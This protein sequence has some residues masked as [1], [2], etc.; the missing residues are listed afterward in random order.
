VAGCGSGSGRRTPSAGQLPLVP[1]ARI[2]A[3]VRACD[4]GSSTYCAIDL[5]VLDH[6][7]S[8]SDALATDE[9]KYLQ[10]AGWS[11]ADADTGV[12]SAANSPGHSLR[13]TFATAVDDL[14]GIDLTWIRRPWPIT[15]ALSNSVF[16]RDAA[17]SIMLEVGAT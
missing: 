15:Y 7:Y 16:D 2:A 6:R 13:V 5:V 1:G 3:E 8:S 9:G 11:I 4:N 14:E 12:Q 17:L 10:K